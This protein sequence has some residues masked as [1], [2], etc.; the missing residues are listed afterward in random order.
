MLKAPRDFVVED[1]MGLNR[2]LG[3]PVDSSFDLTSEILFKYS[4]YLGNFLHRDE[5]DV[6][7][8][9]ERWQIEATYANHRPKIRVRK[10]LRGSWVTAPADLPEIL[11]N[12]V[13]PD[14]HFPFEIRSSLPWNFWKNSRLDVPVRALKVHSATK[15]RYTLDV[16]NVPRKT[17]KISRYLDIG[18]YGF[19]GMNDS[20]LHSLKFPF[21]I[22]ELI[23]V[24]DGLR[25]RAVELHKKTVA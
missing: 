9:A 18:L 2:I 21:R 20:Y 7:L 3:I 17:G 25:L 24:F 10:G 13:R 16:E 1:H 23:D 14:P 5:F 12:I 19:D 15:V 11:G 22:G 8:C 4:C 6:V